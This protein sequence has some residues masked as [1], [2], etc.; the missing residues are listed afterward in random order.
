MSLRRWSAA[1][2]ALLVLA[3]C[4][5]G[6]DHVHDAGAGADDGH[7]HDHGDHHHGP[8]PI[9]FG[10]PAD[11]SAAERTIKVVTRDPLEYDPEVIEVLEGETVTFVV[12]NKGETTHEFVIGDHAYQDAHAVQMAAGDHQHADGNGVSVPP[13]EKRRLTWRFDGAGEFFF[14]CHEPG[15]YAGGMVGRL[16]VA[17]SAP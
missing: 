6:S 10:A 4:G 17:R 7:H 14:G 11:E 1:A 13:G 15:H 12:A 3:A 8:A 2:V 9:S 5:S 16:L